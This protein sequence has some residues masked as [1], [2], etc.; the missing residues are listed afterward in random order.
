MNPGQLLRS[1][2]AILL[3]GGATS[4]I[5]GP[6]D[7]CLKCHTDPAAKRESGAA[8]AVTDAKKF[9]ASV[10]GGKKGKCIECHE[11]AEAPDGKDH[12]KKLKP[13]DCA[14]CHDDAVAEHVKT[15]HGRQRA[16]SEKAAATCTDCHGSAHE[17][18][19]KDDPQSKTNFANIEATCG[20]CH[21]NDK[22]VQA[23]HLPGGNVQ[24]KYHDSIHGRAVRDGARYHA[25]APT[26][27]S[28]H[29]AH[30]ILGKKEKDSKVSF[31]N[32][33][34]TCGGCHQRA[35]VVYDQGKHGALQTKG[36]KTAPTCTDCHSAH[37][38]QRAS[39]EDWKVAVVGQCG[40]CHEDYVTSYHKTYHGKVTNL[41]F[42]D[43]A[44]CAS[45]HG[46]HDIRGASDPTS[47]VAPGNVLQTCQ[48]CHKQA[49]ASFA[50]WDPH[51]RPTD[52]S[53]DPVLYWANIAMNALLAGVFIF[54]GL[55]TLL[56]AYRSYSDWFKRRR[57][58]GSQR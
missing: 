18:L 55:H 35:H 9:V 32:I 10:H 17:I 30:S 33:P 2:C 41:G 28:C 3:L 49:S 47:P 51:P 23:A 48:K 22:V 50:S 52:R 8:M 15:V 4:A 38:I 11:D 5:A 37:S 16:G 25:A 7:A 26:C 13:V 54:F 34:D 58:G 53:R 36:D 45:C 20:S 1:L 40:N 12:A 42:A 44:T 39:Q 31:A 19:A 56:W 57:G 14:S 29:G 24:A 21:G 6:N 43:M 27:T 46:A